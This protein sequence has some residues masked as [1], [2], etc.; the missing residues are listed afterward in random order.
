MKKYINRF[1]WAILF[2]VFYFT[3]FVNFAPTILTFIESF[4]DANSNIFRINFKTTEFRAVNNT[5]VSEDKYVSIDFGILLKFIA[6]FA[7]YVI[8]PLGVIFLMF[9]R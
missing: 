2:L 6:N 9:K 4:V 3:V 7:L 8:I 5:V 1:V